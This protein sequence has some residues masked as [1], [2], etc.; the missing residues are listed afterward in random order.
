MNNATP[1]AMAI[2]VSFSGTPRWSTNARR[3]TQSKAVAANTHATRRSARDQPPKACNSLR[4]ASAPPS[5]GLDDTRH[6]TRV[7]KTY[8]SANMS[9]ENGKA[10][11][12]HSKNGTS[13]PTSSTNPAMATLGG[14]P[15]KVAMPPRLAA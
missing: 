11:M 9:A 8:T 4:N 13:S 7:N 3:A 14:V 15:T 6:R 5:N 1:A 2:V 10:I 12:L